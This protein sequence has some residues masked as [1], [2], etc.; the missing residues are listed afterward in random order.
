MGVKLPWP[1][2]GDPQL[3]S[4]TSAVRAAVVFPVVFAFASQVIGQPQTALFAAFGCYAMLALADFSG[5][6]AVRLLAYL[7]LAIGG[8]VLVVLGTLC[9]RGV[10]LAAGAMAVTGFVILLA[11]VINGYFAAGGTA[12]ILA[13]VLAV[14]IPVP[15]S[16]AGWRLRRTGWPA[17]PAQPLPS[18][19]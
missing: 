8:A 18:P 17:R 15:V 5:R 9:S 7:A 14:S 2:I 4:L 10:W 1:H 13:F 11:G 12:A 19:H 3:A 16:V 6:P